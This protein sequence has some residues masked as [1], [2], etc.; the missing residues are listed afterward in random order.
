MMIGWYRRTIARVK[1]DVR[2]GYLRLD[3]QVFR[4]LVCNDSLVRLKEPRCTLTSFLVVYRN[5][6]RRAKS[7]CLDSLAL[8]P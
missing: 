3:M 8:T 7:R 6:D 1:V 5:M 4:C 2:G